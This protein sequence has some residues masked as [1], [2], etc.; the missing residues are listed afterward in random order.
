MVFKKKILLILVSLVFLGSSVLIGG[1]ALGDQSVTLPYAVMG[2]GWWSRVAITNTSDHDITPVICIYNSDGTSHCANLSTI[3]TG[4][5]YTNLI[6]NFIPSAT[7]SLKVQ[8]SIVNNTDDEFD[9]TLI[10]GTPDGDFGFQSFHSK[11]KKGAKNVVIVDNDIT[12]VTTWLDDSIYIIKKYDFY[13]QNT[14]TIEAGCIVKFHPT[15][16]PDMALSGSGTIIA[17]GTSAKPIIFTS[18]KDDVHGG[19][20]NGD[21]VATSPA[22]KD[23]GEI[24]TNGNNSSIFQYCEFY[25][26]GDSS[27]FATLVIDGDNI[28]VD[29]CKFINN[30]GNSPNSWEGVLNASYGGTGTIISNNIFYNNVKPLT[31]STAFSLD[32]SNR[33]H[34]PNDASQANTYNAVFVETTKDITSAI[35]WMETEVAFVIDDVDWWITSSASL[36]L[37]NDVVLKFEPGATLSLADGAVLVNHNGSGV[38]FTSYKDDSYKGDSNGDGYVTSATDNDWTGIYDDSM[39]TPHPYFFTWTNIHYDSY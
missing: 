34:N 20:Q 1:N 26:G 28:T 14:L 24:S 2:S 8:I 21:G 39:S 35:S 33:F 27:D 29:H 38:V 11:D 22:P 32:D 15:E 37:A 36:T 16:G 23:W 7:L 9:V 10:V 17:R 25:Y 19:D 4:A 31:I 30:D 18:Y 6:E 13:V 12:N 5:V 3:A